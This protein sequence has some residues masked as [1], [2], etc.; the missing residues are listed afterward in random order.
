MEQE[1]QQNQATNV[2]ISDLTPQTKRAN[3][4]AKVMTISESREIP[5]RFG[6]ANTVAEATIGDPTGTVVM[7]LWNDQIN[8]V[9]EGDNIRVENGYVSLL[10]GHIRFNVG[11]YGRIV[12]AEE[13]IAEVNEEANVSDAEHEQ[14]ERP[15]RFGGGGSGGGGGGRSG[16][17]GGGRGGYGGGGGGGGRGGYGGGGGG[18]RDRGY[19]GGGGGGGRGG[20]GDRF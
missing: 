7:S 9:N 4:T 8:Q 6:P 19:G 15:R 14:A 12:P 1:E 20:Y 16:G 5:N 13:D 10:R 11:K 2:K 17:G 18:G 3:L